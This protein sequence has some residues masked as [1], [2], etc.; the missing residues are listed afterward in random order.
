VTFLT[1]G[2]SGSNARIPWIASRF[3]YDILQSGVVKLRLLQ[4]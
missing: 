1:V 3:T 4:V 2:L